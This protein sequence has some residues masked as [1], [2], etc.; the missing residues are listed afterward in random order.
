NSEIHRIK[1]NNPILGLL[2]RFQLGSKNRKTFDITLQILKRILTPSDAS[3]F[4]KYLDAKDQ[5]V[6]NGAFEILCVTGDIFHDTDIFDYFQRYFLSL[7]CLMEKECD[8]LYWL[9]MQLEQYLARYMFMLEEQIP[10]L[11]KQILKIKDVRAK[12]IYISLICKSQKP[13]SVTFMESVYQKEEKL[14]KEILLSFSGNEQ[15]VDFLFDKYKNDPDTR[16]FSIESLLNTEQGLKHFT[17]NFFSLEFEVQE[18]VTIKLPYSSGYDLVDFIKSVFQADVYR[19]KEILMLRVK[20]TF[21]FSVKE[22]LFDPAHEREFMFM[23]NH[24][25]DTI[26]RVFPLTTVKM[27]F[28]KIANGNLSITKTKKFL[29]RIEEIL[30]LELLFTFKDKEMIEKLFNRIII[31][32]NAELNV[33]FF[34]LFKYIKTLDGTTYSNIK[35]CLSIF[36]TKRERNITPKEK[37][38]LRR[39][40]QGMREQFNDLKHMSDGLEEIHSVFG[41]EE[42]DFERLEKLI[43]KHHIAVAL[44]IET[45]I[46]PLVQHFEKVNNETIQGWSKFFAQYPRLASLI[47]ETIDKKAESSEN[48]QFNDLRKLVAT[49]GDEPLRLVL[50][51][52]NRYLTAILK[53]QFEETLPSLNMVVNEDILE[54]ED[55]LLCDTEIIN[56]LVLQS[57]TIPTKLFVF[58][59]EASGATAFRECKPVTF[60]EPFSFSRIVRQILQNLYL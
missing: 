32:N 42:I 56:D 21:E 55:I 13:A 36:I 6:A 2:P 54:E 5:M 59:E 19:L 16:E 37:G 60:V 34:S 20:E 50:N 58:L 23:G 17:E 4:T 43:T 39:V 41:A 29:T 28:N 46:E 33:Q 38:E 40:T 8:G 11:E 45:F 10:N 9:L 48:L 22:I 35:D 31:S 49:L 47:T 24:Y 30:P 14:R 12:T 3:I 1:Q 51:F 53:E 7:P 15:A 44:N 27:F 57:Q 52:K 25:L 26:T 18:T